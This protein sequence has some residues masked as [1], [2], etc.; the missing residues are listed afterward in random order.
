MKREAIRKLEAWKE[1]TGRQPLLLMGARQVGKTWLMR[2]FGRQNYREV[3][4]VSFDNSELMR[5]AFEQDLDVERL[6]AAIRLHTGCRV[7]PG[8]TLII[9]DEI[10]ECPRAITS[11]KY[12]CEDAA[13]YHVAAAGSLLGLY[14]KP[15][16]TGFPVG[17]VDILDVYPMSFTEFLDALEMEQMT[18]AI[19]EHAWEQM[20]LFSV[21]LEELLRYYY[22]IGG[23]PGVV[24][25]FVKTRDF[26][27]V[28]TKQNAI[29]RGYS[30]DIG[31]HA[32]ASDA[33]HIASIWEGIPHQLAQEEKE[34]RMKIPRRVYPLDWLK[35]AG[36]IHR[37]RCARTA[38]IPLSAY[39]ENAFK[40][41]FTDV[42]LLAAQSKLDRRVLLEKNKVFGQYKGAL[43]EQ[44]VLQQL[45]TAGESDSYYWKAER[46]QAEVDFLLQTWKGV[47]P[48]EVKAE[49]NL[50]AKSLLSFCK[51]FSPPL[52]LRCSMTPFATS[53]IA[54]DAQRSCT[55]LDVPL[56][57][58][59]EIP[60]ILE[61]E[62]ERIAAEDA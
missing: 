26:A 37:V 4:Y 53:R 35:S 33:R 14:T 42:G 40:I 41:Y 1:K 60:S 46:A 51:R 45:L 39:P 16:G 7:E 8:K 58:A 29:L 54:V 36:L 48:L 21:K 55:L 52:A 50:R 20:N 23:M 43:T 10:Q 47:V 28:R 11:L 25:E 31:K 49:R 18:G 59:G 13:Q 34:F 32:T 2:E 44:Y 57:A 3:A 27:S 19:R 38:Q 24:A 15:G 5:R 30:E 9:L 22:Y 17:K 62:L 61:T 12:F 6:L 56:W